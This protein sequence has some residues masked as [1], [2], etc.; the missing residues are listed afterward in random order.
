VTSAGRQISALQIESE[1]LYFRKHDGMIG[2]IAAVSLSM[3]ADAINAVKGLLKRF[4]A[5]R[6]ASAARHGATMLTLLFKTGLAS[7]PT[8]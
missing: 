6:M 3:L 7:R 4:D 2:V 1:L 5:T 8:R